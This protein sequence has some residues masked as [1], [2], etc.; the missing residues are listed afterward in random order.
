[1]GAD[2][3]GII[4]VP[5]NWELLDFGTEPVDAFLRTIDFFVYFTHPFWQ[6]SFG[7]VIAEAIAAGKVVITSH[8]TAATFGDAV[9]AANPEDVDEIIAR[10]IAKPA[11]YTSQ[12]KRSQTALRQFSAS[13]FQ[14]RFQQLLAQTSRAPQ[15]AN[16]LEAVY[17]FL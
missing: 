9:I 6:E 8:A 12:V 11:L 7:R 2:G 10:F 17:D 5:S 14:D 3:L 4:D 13:A 1:L 15:P 16:Q